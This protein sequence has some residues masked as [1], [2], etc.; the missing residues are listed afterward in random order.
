[1]RVSRGCV[2]P[3]VPHQQRVGVGVEDRHTASQG[4]TESFAEVSE[5]RQRQAG[6][7]FCLDVALWAGASMTRYGNDRACRH[8][9]HRRC[10]S[11]RLGRPGPGLGAACSQFG[12]LFP[13]R[14]SPCLSGR[15]EL[16]PPSDQ[17]LPGHRGGG[18]EPTPPPPQVVDIPLNSFSIP[19]SSVCQ[20][21]N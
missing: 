5:L 21:T 3:A 8:T 6:P 19:G 20:G 12:L 15:D 13:W 10:R 1:M 4:Q 17:E 2:W 9:H 14:P 7:R 18:L 11:Q 16:L